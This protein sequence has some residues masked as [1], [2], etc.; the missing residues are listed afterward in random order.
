MELQP[1]K[2]KQDGASHP[3]SAEV[4]SCMAEAQRGCS[5]ERRPLPHHQEAGLGLSPS[6]QPCECWGHRE[7]RL[8]GRGHTQLGARGSG[9]PRASAALSGRWGTQ[10]PVSQSG[11]MCWDDSW[12]VHGR[13]I[14]IMVIAATMQL[15]KAVC[16]PP[17]AAQPTHRVTSTPHSLHPP[18]APQLDSLGCP[19]PE[20]LLGVH[21]HRGPQ[22]WCWEWSPGPAVSPGRVAFLHQGDGLWAGDRQ[23]C[24]NESVS[25]TRRWHQGSH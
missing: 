14:R 17:P 2:V 19:S 13:A 4:G 20:S 6:S 1:C 18:W 21:T 3:H 24:G 11:R 12:Q 8:T 7:D 5:Q 9:A 23:G 25:W 10:M 16:P 22:P 15:S